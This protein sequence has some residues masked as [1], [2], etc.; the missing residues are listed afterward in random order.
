M[1]KKKTELNTL[2]KVSVFSKEDSKVNEEI[3]NNEKATKSLLEEKKN[4]NKNTDE[5]K[6]NKPINLKEEV[7][8]FSLSSLKIR[9]KV[10]DEIKKIEDSREKKDEIININNLKE[11][12]NIYASNLEKK[13]K[14]NFSSFF[15]TIGQ[16]LISF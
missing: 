15:K 12:W 8:A 9:K 16:T 6:K 5:D 11:K 3:Y 2:K 1:K 10:T 4:Q 7:S 14:G 13:G